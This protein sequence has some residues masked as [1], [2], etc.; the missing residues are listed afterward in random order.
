MKYSVQSKEVLKDM[1]FIF[2]P[3]SNNSK[4]VDQYVP[5]NKSLFSQVTEYA[6]Q[7]LH[8]TKN[9][10]KEAYEK[11]DIGA[12][13]ICSDKDLENFGPKQISKIMENQ[14]KN[15][16]PLDE[17]DTFL[18]ETV[19]AKEFINPFLSQKG[20][21]SFF[22][23]LMKSKDLNPRVFKKLW[24][25]CDGS[26]CSVS[27]LDVAQ[28]KLSIEG[29]KTL[30][31]HQ[32]SAHG[33]KNFVA[34]IFNDTRVMEEMALGKLE[35]LCN[36]LL[37]DWSGP[38]KTENVI[39][40]ALAMKSSELLNHFKSQHEQKWEEYVIPLIE[41]GSFL[42][43]LISGENCILT[44]GIQNAIH[45]FIEKRNL[46]N[47]DIDLL[48]KLNNR[49]VSKAVV[50]KMTHEIKMKTG[51]QFLKSC[52][53]AENWDSFSELAKDATAVKALEQETGQTIIHYALD[54]GRKDVLKE[55]LKNHAN[56]ASLTTEK[57]DNVIVE[58]LQ[59]VQ[60]Y[61]KY[62]KLPDI[63]M[64]LFEAQ[65]PKELEKL[66]SKTPNVCHVL[67]ENGR[68]NNAFGFLLKNNLMKNERDSK[69]RLPIYYTLA[70]KNHELTNLLLNKNIHLKDVDGNGNH[71]VHISLDDEKML[72]LLLERNSTWIDIENSKG[73]TVMMLVA[74]DPT[75]HHLF[76]RLLKYKPDLQKR[77]KEFGKTIMHWCSKNN[78]L[79]ASLF[80]HCDSNPCLFSLPDNDG[81][82]PINYNPIHDWKAQFCP[83][84]Q[85]W[86]QQTRIL[87]KNRN[88]L[89]ELKNSTKNFKK[90]KD[91]FQHG[92]GILN[93]ATQLKLQEEVSLD[94]IDLLLELKLTSGFK[95]SLKMAFK[96]WDIPLIKKLLAEKKQCS[97]IEYEQKEFCQFVETANKNKSSALMVLSLKLPEDKETLISK[98]RENVAFSTNELI[99]EQNFLALVDLNDKNLTETLIK[100]LSKAQKETI[101]RKALLRS[102]E[103]K[104]L[105]SVLPLISDQ[106][107]PLSTPESTSSYLN[108]VIFQKNCL[109][110][111]ALVPSKK[112]VTREL[113]QTKYLLFNF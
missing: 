15:Q 45:S 43:Q 30:I 94:T 5:E 42:K 48:L 40:I 98:L 88:V 89:H 110:I 55:L 100:K 24:E 2:Q 50:R 33:N 23:F 84:K 58:A 90:W 51:F 77:E 68:Y 81:N 7:K 57:R 87:L 74:K 93:L 34:D 47:D 31:C 52:L 41:R 72:H 9:T 71:A 96:E 44:S 95:E 99:K 73:E 28:N 26:K 11:N 83:Q 8:L 35:N 17:L 62:T 111:F 105:E 106:E 20:K 6:S 104:H 56:L 37:N 65:P 19:I 79:L 32:K 66:L 3:T 61:P 76:K 60:K 13:K 39:T 101:G 46:C 97:K 82:L 86:S 49:D 69:N 64:V 70:N 27:M 59:M 4:E 109:Q 112:P 67:A 103:K 21:D 53:V 91:I 18:I 75:Y 14:M 25:K 107:V 36:Y 85:C 102:L 22:S 63:L 12:L 29:I 10:A 78:D 16:E 92:N 1:F 113:R 80:G 54:V 108:Q 38:G